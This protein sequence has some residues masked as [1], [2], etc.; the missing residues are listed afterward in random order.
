MQDL[1]V[2]V[3]FT[4]LDPTA[5]AEYINTGRVDIT[6]VNFTVTKE[7]TGQVDFTEPYMKV[8]LG[9]ISPEKTV[10][11]LVDELKGKTL[12]ITKDTTAETYFEKNYPEVELQ[13]YDACADA[14]NTLL[15][16]RNGALLTDNT[17][18]IA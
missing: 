2:R 8:A 16:G 14:Y 18:V 9:V 13:K 5:R 10:I 7:R 12:I 15:D 3:E 1:G 11:H 6:L 17:E 4:S